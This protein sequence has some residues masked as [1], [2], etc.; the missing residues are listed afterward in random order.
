MQ[1]DVGNEV[2]VA[3]VAVGVLAFVI[4]FAVVLSLSGAG[5]PDETATQQ[6][7]VVTTSTTE[8]VVTTREITVSPPTAIEL[9]PSSTPTDRPASA[10]TV[11]PTS[12]ETPLPPSFTPTRI[13]AS[14]TNTPLPPTS[15]PTPIPSTAT[16]TQ[17]EADTAVVPSATNTIRPSSTPQPTATP[18]H[19][20][21]ATYTRTATAVPSRTPTYTPT[22][23]ATSTATFTPTRTP[24][25]TNTPTRTPRPTET[26]G[27]RPTP[28]GTHTPIAPI[29][30][31][32]CTPQA[33]WY[34]YTVRSGET[35]S[36]ISR[37][38]G[39]SIATL[40]RANCLQDV[41]QIYAGQRILVPRMP[42]E[43]SSL[44]GITPGADLVIEGCSAPSTQITNLTAGQL[45]SGTF[46]VRGTASAPNFQY[47]K[48][49]V[50]PDFARVFNFYSRSEMPVENGLL[51]T[52]D[53]AIF[54]R[55][56][57][58]IK[59]TVITDV[60]QTPC[61]IPVIFQ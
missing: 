58:W 17:R 49:E 28:T 21:T 3:I 25:P 54:G 50:R 12:T 22:V 27:I 38:V 14:A 7:A 26:S 48:I 2:I 59:L 33:G 56:L 42:A 9:I 44:P 24:S 1:R 15:T 39:A 19:T 46:S 47:Y 36:M 45:I 10:T 35:L 37:A 8:S 29:L 55:G 31:P 41:N 52:I 53:A 34:S 60:Y 18:S 20:L 5:Q 16:P 13:P 61:V 57:H 30:D 40:Q 23:T 51:A 6:A 32:V 4:M 11:P 43:A